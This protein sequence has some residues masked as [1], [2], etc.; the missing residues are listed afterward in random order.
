MPGGQPQPDRVARPRT[1]SAGALLGY[2]AQWV[3]IGFESPQLIKCLL[4]RF[5]KDSRAALP[6]L[7]YLH[8]RMAEGL[9][10]MCGGKFRP[11]HRPF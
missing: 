1:K 4:P 9:V 11:G 3:D 6:L 2:L 7:D 8:L 10:A 5:P